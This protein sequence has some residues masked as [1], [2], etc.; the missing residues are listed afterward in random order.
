MRSAVIYWISVF[1]LLNLV[2]CDQP[3]HCKY[4]SIK[5]LG[6]KDNVVGKWEFTATIKQFKVDLFKMSA[7]CTH[8][9]PNRI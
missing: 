7:V 6:L 3:V 2:N 9:A 8:E 4:N 5:F 1:S